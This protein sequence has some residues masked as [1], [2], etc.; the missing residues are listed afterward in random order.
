[1]SSKAQ[2]TRGRTRPIVTKIV[3]KF[4]TTIPPE[5]REIYGLREG[6]LIEWS[7]SVQTSKLVLS[8]KR[9]HLLTPQVKAE[10]EDIKAER[11]KARLA[12]AGAGD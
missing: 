6:D 12:L 7:F 3:S 2:A 5:M 10:I 8:P 11:A 1:M 4:Q 9:A